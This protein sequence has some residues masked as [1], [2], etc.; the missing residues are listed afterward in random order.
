MLTIISKK[1]KKKDSEKRLLHWLSAY[2]FKGVFKD[3]KLNC[4]KTKQAVLDM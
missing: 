1:K 4:V 2:L 3:M